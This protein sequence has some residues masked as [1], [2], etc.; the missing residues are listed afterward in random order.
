MEYINRANYCDSFVITV[1]Q[2]KKTEINKKSFV[3]S[4][5]EKFTINCNCSNKSKKI[6]RKIILSFLKRIVDRYEGNFK[7]IS[8]NNTTPS[9]HIPNI[10]VST[11]FLFANKSSE[12]SERK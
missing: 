1:K 5:E 3:M 8:M 7:E 10:F 4:S 9:S 2:K 12:S 6:R 11:F